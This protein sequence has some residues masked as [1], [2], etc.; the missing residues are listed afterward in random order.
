MGML[1]YELELD[2]EELCALKKLLLFNSLY[3]LD[4][5]FKKVEVDDLYEVLKKVNKLII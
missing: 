2:Q 5:N 1:D 3:E 4:K